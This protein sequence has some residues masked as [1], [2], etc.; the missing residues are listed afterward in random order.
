[1]KTIAI[2][3]ASGFIG[4]NLVSR[5]RALDFDLIEVPRGLKGTDL[6]TLL[7]PADAVIHLAGVNRPEKTADFWS[8]NVQRTLELTSALSVLERPVPLVYAS[9]IQAEQENEYG[10]SKRAAEDIVA[11]YGKVSNSSVDIVRLPNVFGKWCKPNYNSVVATFCYNIARNLPIDVRD[12]NAIV[13]LIYVDDVVR[14]FLDSLNGDVQTANLGPIYKVSLGELSNTIKEFYASR[15]NLMPG[16]VGEGFRRALHATY[17]SYLPPE[18]FSYGLQSNTDARGMFVEVLRT[19]ADG[20]FSFFTAHPGVTRGG[21]FHHTKTE[22]F[23]VVSGKARF[24]FRNIIT[25]ETYETIVSAE[26]ARVVETVPGWS[27]DLTNIGDDTLVV[28]LWA[29]EVFDMDNPDTYA[30]SVLANE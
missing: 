22:K 28:M 17:L 25:N 6:T 26:Q 27:H 9:S 24:G 13:D 16:P 20:Q 19:A 15:K 3:G 4:K 10:V 2:T 12:P 7:E 1:M 30:A 23:I 29:N 21:H 5:C 14:Y 18:T 11:E 8:G